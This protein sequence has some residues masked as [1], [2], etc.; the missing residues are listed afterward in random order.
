MKQ[1]LPRLDR[2]R[3]PYG[4]LWALLMALALASAA[5]EAAPP[6]PKPGPADS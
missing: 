4:E 2:P 1:V 3:K 6:A 5:A